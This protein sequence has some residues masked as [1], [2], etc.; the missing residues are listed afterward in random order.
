MGMSN[1]TT[2]TVHLFGRDEVTQHDSLEDV[3]TRIHAICSVNGLVLSAYP[4]GGFGE[5]VHP[6]CPVRPA[7]PYGTYKIEEGN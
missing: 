3:R 4:V 2:L 7:Y 6:A 5:F 1:T